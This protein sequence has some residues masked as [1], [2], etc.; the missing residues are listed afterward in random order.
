MTESTHEAFANARQFIPGDIPK[1][2]GHGRANETDTGFWWGDPVDLTSSYCVK[3][4]IPANSVGSFY[5]DP[6]TAKTGLIIDL[7]AKIVA[8]KPWRGY[9]VKQAG[10]IYVAL[11]G[12]QGIGRRIEAVR[13][14]EPE[15]GGKLPLWVWSGPLNLLERVTVD[16][17]IRLAR[18]LFEARNEQLGIVVIDTLFRATAGYDLKKSEVATG[19]LAQIERI[20]TELG[21]TVIVIAHKPRG[22][23]NIFGSVAFDACFDFMFEVWENSGQLGFTNTKQKDYERCV[24]GAF[25]TEQIEL[26]LDQDGD[27]ITSY[28]IRH[29]GVP[30]KRVRKRPTGIVGHGLEVLE[31]MYCDDDWIMPRPSIREI[32][33]QIENVEKNDDWRDQCQKRGLTEKKSAFR[34]AFSKTRRGLREGRWIGVSED[35]VWL[36]QEPE[37]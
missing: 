22:G 30:E 26:G 31:D 7:L 28:A 8:G 12:Q 19:A 6:G 24:D 23:E 9:R 35:Y 29:E 1:S 15:L 37:K 2:N 4:V 34:N 25:R 18:S 33:N 14:A 21:A 32:P 27:P 13:M 3:G 5:G 16:E 20:K 36:I 17:F 11:E 10:G